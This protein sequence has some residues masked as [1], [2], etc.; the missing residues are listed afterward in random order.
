MKHEKG[1]S[2]YIH[3]FGCQMNQADSA[4]ITAI[5][6]DGGFRVA[7]S[8]EDADIVILNTC[9]VRENAV[10]RITHQLQFLRGQKGG[11]NHFSLVLQAVCRST[12]KERC[13][14]CF[15]SLIFSPAPI[16]IETCP[17]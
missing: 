12:L 2:F 14:R 9:A 3:T 4:I 16:P 8:Q 13:W 1:R 15:P 17:R 7:G 6:M 10:E 11:R 5:L